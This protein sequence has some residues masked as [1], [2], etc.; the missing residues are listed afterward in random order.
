MIEALLREGHDLQLLMRPPAAEL[1]HALLPEAEVHVIGSDPWHGTTRQ[2]LDPFAEDFEVLARFNPDM[3]VAA[4]FQTTLFD[5]RW[6]AS[7]F[8][9][10]RS[11]GFVSADGAGAEVPSWSVA[12]SVP[13]AMSEPEKCRHLALAIT[14][15]EMRFDPPR[16]PGS[17]DVA[18]AEKLLAEIGVPA[19]GFI[20]VC[21]GNRPGLALKDWGE[22]R[23]ARLLAAMAREDRR[24]L[25]FLG[26]PKEAASIDRIREALP[27]GT[28]SIS[29]ASTP[30]PM[31]VTHA[32]VSL[33]AAYLGRD[34]G[35]MHLAAATGR[36]L[37]A[38]FGGAHW[39]RFVPPAPEGVILTRATPCRG[40][41]FD[42]P[43]P[44]PYC[45]S[46]IPE[47]YVLEAWRSL[48]STHGLR[49]I[50]IPPGES[51]LEQ[52]RE[53]MTRRNSRRTNSLV[54]TLQAALGRLISGA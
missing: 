34:S 2:L 26:N 41:N 51:W 30:P 35:P 40:C 46:G 54:Q 4:A 12:V 18:R 33:S 36:P 20:V 48:G 23:W 43:F 47:E 31:P 53:V 52:H 5:E 28:T 39:P 49:V 19:H 37:L 1:A 38:L 7:S 27:A 16:Q 22:S 21:A 8:A 44:E 13:V 9:R 15:H 6:L 29:L 45:V 24:P 10:I 17:D 32:L 3:F 25:V 14:G 11:V 42:C 50:Q